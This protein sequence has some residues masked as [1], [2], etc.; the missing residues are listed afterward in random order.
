MRLPILKIFNYIFNTL[1]L[2]MINNK[3]KFQLFKQQNAFF[4]SCGIRKVAIA[5]KYI[6]RFSRLC[7][8]F[9]A[10]IYIHFLSPY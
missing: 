2:S 10:M 8:F 7:N 9:S 6:T 1:N 5:E 4:G 3:L